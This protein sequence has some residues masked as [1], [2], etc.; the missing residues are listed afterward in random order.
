MFVAEELQHEYIKKMHMTVVRERG[1][2]GPRISL[3]ATALMG[4]RMRSFRH[5]ARIRTRPVRDHSGVDVQVLRH[6]FRR[7]MF[8]PV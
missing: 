3:G 6:H 1:T 4:A 5:D 2:H 8:K 7:R